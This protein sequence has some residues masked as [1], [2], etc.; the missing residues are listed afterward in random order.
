MATSQDQ[1]TMK[2]L[3]EAGVHMGH[4][5]HRWNPK[6]RPYIHSTRN[7][8]H[9][10]DLEQTLPALQKACQFVAEAAKKRSNIVFVGTK[11]QAAEIIQEEATR[12]RA[13][14]VSR[15]WLGGM[16]T[17]FETV[18]LRIV[19]LRELE[20][21]RETGEFYR[22]PKKEVA[23]LNRELLKLEKSLGG[24]KNMH[25]K[26]DVLFVI[27]V[28]RESLAI[29]EAKK[30]GATVVAVVDTNCDPDRVDYVIPGNDDSMRSIKLIV[31]AV[32]DAIMGVSQDAPPRTDGPDAQPSGV[33]G[34]SGR[35]S[36]GGSESG[37]ET[38]SAS[39]EEGEGGGTDENA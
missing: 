34:R 9:I 25:G 38:E 27:D 1:I 35:P 3:V 14:Y 29:E 26:P 18:R 32:A 39:A 20:Q 19:R 8:I 11:K 6:M 36:D 33:P 2:T 28:N 5:T 30:I 24:L 31:S 13:H 12:C 7:G 15:R 17:N 23:V 22:R 4:Q 10:I 21:M 16:L 37:N